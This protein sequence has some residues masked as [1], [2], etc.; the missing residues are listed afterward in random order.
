MGRR[1]RVDHERLRVAHVR[2]VARKLQ[3]VDDE[4]ADVRVALHAE[5]EDA[6]V[7]LRAQETGRDGMRGVRGQ[8]RVFHPCDLWVLFQ[9][10]IARM[11]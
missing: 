2:E 1:R 3:L 6:A 9:P 7:R 8:T 10:S 11:S 5:G 4:A